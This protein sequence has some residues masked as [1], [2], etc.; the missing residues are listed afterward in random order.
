MASTLRNDRIEIIKLSNS[1]TIKD[2][3]SAPILRTLEAQY[4]KDDLA[5]V[6]AYQIMQTAAF[7]NLG[8]NIREDQALET[9]YLILEKYPAET[10]QDFT[11]VFKNAK[12]GKYGELYNRLD[13]QTI[14]KWIEAYL[15]QKAEF[16][17]QL[18]KQQK[19]NGIQ[20]DQSARLMI[21]TKM[22]EGKSVID[23]LKEG[24]GYEKMKKDDETYREYKIKYLQSRIKDDNQNNL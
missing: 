20:H 6:I 4:G 19:A 3:L 13:G 8:N 23:A 24:I 9:A 14:F 5:T 1:I 21:E 15:D 18:H 11:L 17:E 10:L 16:R 22:E 7:F 12:T 2:S